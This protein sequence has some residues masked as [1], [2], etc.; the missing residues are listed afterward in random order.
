M[1]AI[2]FLIGDITLDECLEYISQELSDLNNQ[3]T[4]IGEMKKATV[5]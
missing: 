1:T 3:S 4:D 5:R 2:S